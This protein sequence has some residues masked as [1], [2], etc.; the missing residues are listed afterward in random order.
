MS[1]IKV[2]NLCKKYYIGQTF[3]Q[4]SLR[5]T[6]IQKFRSLI[7]KKNNKTKHSSLYALNDVSFSLQQGDLLGVIGKNGSGKS[8]LLKILSRITQPTSGK[9]TIKG[10]VASLLEVGTGFHHELTGRENIFLNGVI[11]GMSHNEIKKRFDEIVAFSGVEQF[12]DTPVKRYSSGMLLRLAFSVAAHIEP[13]IL[14]VDEVLAV[15]DFEFQKKC[16]AVMNKLG[17][18]GKTII[19]VSHNIGSIRKFCSKALLLSQGKLIAEGLVNDVVNTYLID[20]KTHRCTIEWN[21]NKN[22]QNN[23]ITMK[24]IKAFNSQGKKSDFFNIHE[25]VFVEVEYEIKK[26]GSKLAISL[27][28]YDAQGTLLFVTMDSSNTAWQEKQRE[29]GWYKSICT[30]PKDFLNNG[31]ITVSFSIIEEGI[32]TIIRAENVISFSITDDM[33]GS[34]ARGNF[35]HVWPRTAI[36]PTLKWEIDYEQTK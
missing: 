24:S 12:I 29:K 27:S 23:I 8:T 33:V 31:E 16:F 17:S 14:I 20:G 6:I 32:K 19:F 26:P 22:L 1:Q 18:S 15:G 9:V 36:R 35:T 13:E 10:R 25:N 4:T 2:E 7:G 30:V 3:Q 21:K 11:L 28:F 5:D 34:G